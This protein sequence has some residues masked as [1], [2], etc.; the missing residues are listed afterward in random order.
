MK[1]ELKPCHECTGVA[2]RAAREATQSIVRVLTATAAEQDDFVFRTVI[3]TVA[4][5]ITRDVE[6]IARVCAA[7]TLEQ[8]Q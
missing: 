5:S 8:P 4:A 1:E 7:R 2:E 6:R 3:E